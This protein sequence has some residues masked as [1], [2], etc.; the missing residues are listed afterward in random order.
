MMEEQTRIGIKKGIV[1]AI[2]V[3][4]GYLPVGIAFGLLA[5][6]S[7][8]DIRD[9][10]LFSFIV[11][12]GASQFM[13]LD[14]IAAGVSTGSIILA[15]LL[16]N[17]RHMVMS[18]SLSIKLDN[19]GR[20]YLPIL[21]FGI[22]DETFSLLSFTKESL[23]TPFVLTVNILSYIIWGLSSIL[24][25]AVGEILPQSLQS[26]LGIGLYAMFVALLF[27]NFKSDKNT[28]KLSIMTAIIY[29]IIYKTGVF[30]GGWDIILGI[31]VSSF[32]GVLV[33]K[34]RGVRD[35]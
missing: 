34:D 16:L 9:T 31:L 35:N 20:K 33:L 21:A 5:K 26:S 32:V 11:Y 1:A 14:L 22:T 7:G 4:L 17:L 13:A 15:T 25:F 2:P 24:G 23:N 19:V 27:P 6:N 30:T 12:A 3:L 8:L 18:A 29:I 28:L 10:G